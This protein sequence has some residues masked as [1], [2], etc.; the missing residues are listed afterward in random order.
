MRIIRLF[1]AMITIPL[2]LSATDLTPWLTKDFEFQ[3][4]LSGLFQYYPKIASNHGSIH[5]KG[6]DQFYT[7]SLGLSAFDWSGE[8]EST[9]AHTRRQDYLCDNIRL[10][11]RYRWLDDIPGE[12]PV[13]LTTGVTLTQAFKHSL[14][15]ISSFH[16]GQFEGE[17]HVAIGQESSCNRFWET[18]WWGVLALG[19]GNHGAPW[20]RTETAWE[21]NW[22]NS[23]QLRL[24]AN[25][26]WGLG[27]KGISSVDHFRGYGPIAHQSIDLG[28][29]YTYLFDF[30]GTLS[31]EYAYRVYAS[32]FPES[33]SLLMLRY[34]YP[35]GL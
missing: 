35:F 4:Q 7:L 19:H 25:T 15:D 10:T 28:M 1:A 3:S 8:I 29:R 5:R 22:W 30:S 34:L 33:T 31:L 23:H 12:V 9:L 32:N 14:R 21:K 27:N 6:N 26:L 18:R 24:F 11:G 17:L 20:I 2:L 16:H 13:S